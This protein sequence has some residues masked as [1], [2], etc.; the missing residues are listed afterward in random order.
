MTSCS[1]SMIKI[2]VLAMAQG[3]GATSF[4]K[5]VARCQSSCIFSLLNLAIHEGARPPK[6]K[7]FFQILL[8]LGLSVAAVF[9]APAPSPSK[10]TAFPQ[11]NSDLKPDPP[12][13]FERLR[14]AFANSCFRIRSRKAELLFGFLFF[15]ARFTER[16]N[17]ADSAIFPSNMP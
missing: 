5:G 15:R 1:S 14:T 13:A 9:A 2:F 11:E 17:Q 3:R 16:K 8:I 4:A 12:H 10:S 7:L 6:I